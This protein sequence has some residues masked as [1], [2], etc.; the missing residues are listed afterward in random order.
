MVC[1][2]RY[3]IL[4]C[5]RRPRN[6]VRGIVPGEA[7]A[8]GSTLEVL[9]FE[10]ATYAVGNRLLAAISGSART[11]RYT[12]DGGYLEVEVPKS[13]QGTTPIIFCAP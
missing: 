12:T 3:F 4:Q 8:D 2:A 7:G 1:A 11:P 10:T 9:L 6:Y 5:I 13:P